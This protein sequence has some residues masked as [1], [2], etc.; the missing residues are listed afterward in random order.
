MNWRASAKRLGYSTLAQVP[1]IRLER[2][3]RGHGQICRQPVERDPAEVAR[4]VWLAIPRFTAD[5]AAKECRGNP[6][7]AF[8]W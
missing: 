1:E 4:F 8:V 5:D 3:A 6:V 2:I 7:L